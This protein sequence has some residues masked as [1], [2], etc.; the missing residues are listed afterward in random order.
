MQALA[1]ITYRPNWDKEEK[2]V[3][4]LLL[5]DVLAHLLD[6]QLQ[7]ANLPNCQAL[8]WLSEASRN[9]VTDFEV[10]L[11]FTPDAT[12]QQA[13][14][15]ADGLRY[16]LQRLLATHNVRAS[17]RVNCFISVYFAA[18]DQD[19]TVKSSNDEGYQFNLVH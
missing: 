2:E 12:P 10:A 17:F 18:I 16:E 9:V 13:A 14:Q 5:N 11:R 1:M 6:Q 3:N 15:V 19:G 8:Q 4:L 7:K